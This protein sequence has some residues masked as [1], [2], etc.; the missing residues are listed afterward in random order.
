MVDDVVVEIFRRN[1]LEV[2]M[3]KSFQFRMIGVDSLDVERTVLILPLWNPNMG[4]FV[5]VGDLMIASQVVCNEYRAFLNP[6]VQYVFQVFY[7]GPSQIADLPDAQPVKIDDAGNADLLTRQ[8]PHGNLATS[9]MRL[10]GQ[11]E[12]RPLEVALE[13]DM[14]ERLVGLGN[15]VDNDGI[16]HLLERVE[17]LVPPDERRRKVDAADVG[18]FSQRELVHQALEIL[19]PCFD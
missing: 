16:V 7:A 14:E 3:N 6:S 18:A 8:S 15:A 1:A 9:L 4:K 13:A 2:A 11:R 5:L 12:A 10:S 19:F 17:Y